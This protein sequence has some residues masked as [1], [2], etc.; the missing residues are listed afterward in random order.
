VLVPW[1]ARPVS[2]LVRGRSG[3]WDPAIFGL[4][5]ADSFF[6]AATAALI[7]VLGSHLGDYPVSLVAALLYLVNFAVP[8]LRL[9]GLVDAGEAFFLAALL[10]IL[11]ERQLWLLPLVAMLGTWSKESFVPLSFVFTAS[12]WSVARK[13]LPLQ[14]A[15][16]IVSSWIVSI[17]ALVGV[18]RW[19]AGYWINPL[20]F[21]VSLH[22][23]QQYLG[24]FI[25]SL[26]DR[27]FWYV[28]AWLLPL[29]IPNLRRLPGSWLIPTGAASLMT[30]ILDGYYGGAPGTV[31]RAL[32]SVASPLLV[33]SSALLLLGRT[34]RENFAEGE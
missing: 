20:A 12:W 30:F 10:W 23:N 28:F 15:G 34:N 2:Q 8:N 21:G 3:S 18:Q 32:F 1:I 17:A 24:H 11:S 29:G 4:L 25:S 16:W 6:V 33:L 13:G 5:V 22:G 31:S 19:V 14:S 26:R 7:V 9:V 27:N